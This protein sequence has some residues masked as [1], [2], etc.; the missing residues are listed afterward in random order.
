MIRI[1]H[2]TNY[3]FSSGVFIEPHFLRFKPKTT[4]FCRLTQFD[5]SVHPQ[6]AGI[7][8]MVDPENNDIQFCWFDDMHKNLSIKTQSLIQTEDFNPFNFL[9]YP[10]RFNALPFSYSQTDLKVLDTYLSY[11]NL[12][13]DL[14][15]FGE[16]LLLKSYNE[17]TAFLL[18]LTKEIH[19]D[20]KIETREEGPPYEPHKTFMLKKGSCRDLSWM[21]L[22]L[23]RYLGMASKFVSGYYYLD[24]E[25]AEFELHA[26]VQ[27][28][29]PGAGWIGFDP[30]H[31]IITANHHFPVAESF[32][33]SNTMPVSGTLRGEASS[34]MSVNLK[35]E[36]L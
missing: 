29:I 18:N 16:Q 10:D 34:K 25:H 14:I 31:G 17:T 30:S 3:T 9:I 22:N 24:L 19:K 20:F 7:S 1:V 6:P 2:E 23:L 27:V 12:S 8:N 11:S 28:F 35:I 5:I 26:W 4:P 13:N 33:F 36:S 32:T 15:N 21:M